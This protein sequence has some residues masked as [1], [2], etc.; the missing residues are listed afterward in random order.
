MDIRT[1][2]TYLALGPLVFGS[3][4]AGPPADS[5]GA[6]VDRSTGKFAAATERAASKDAI[7]VDD[8]HWLQGLQGQDGGAGGAS[9]KRAP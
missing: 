6:R 1:R 8:A 9:L 4:L 5:A 2:M 3:F 7:N